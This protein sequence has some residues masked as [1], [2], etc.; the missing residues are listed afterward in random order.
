M[1]LQCTRPN[2][3]LQNENAFFP[4]NARGCDGLAP[5]GG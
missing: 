2:R 3:E 5:I 4:E 1:L